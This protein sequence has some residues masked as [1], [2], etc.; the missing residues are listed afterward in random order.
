MDLQSIL[1]RLLIQNGDGTK[2]SE[3]IASDCTVSGRPFLD[4]IAKISDVFPNGEKYSNMMATFN[5]TR[6]NNNSTD[7]RLKLYARIALYNSNNGS[8]LYSNTI[9]WGSTEEG[10]KS[11]SMSLS[12]IE[13]YDYIGFEMWGKAAYVLYRRTIQLKDWW[14]YN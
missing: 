7:A 10:K 3:L 4:G 13:K 2:L 9:E 11:V 5:G 12:E 1:R 8:V 14:L 6:S